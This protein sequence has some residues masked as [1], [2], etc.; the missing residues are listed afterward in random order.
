MRAVPPGQ[1]LVIDPTLE[2]GT[3]YGPDT[4]VSPLYDVAVDGL[5]NVYAAGMTYAGSTEN[6]ATTGA[7]L[8]TY[9]GNADAYL[10]KFDSSGNRLW[11]TYY[12]G[13]DLD[14]GYAV[15]ADGHH[16]VYLAGFTMS[17]D[18][19]LIATPGSLQ[20]GNGGGGNGFLAKFDGNG[21]RLWATFYGGDQQDELYSVVCDGSNNVII[22]GVATSTFNIATPG[23]FED[24]FYNPGYQYTAGLLA[25]F[26]SVGDRL[27]GTYYK[28]FTDT[29]VVADV[30][31][32]SVATDGFNLYFSAWTDGGD[33]VTTPG[34]WQPDFQGTLSNVLLAKFNDSGARQWATF[35]GGSDQ[36]NSGSVACDK[37]GNVY[38]M[39]MTT[40]DSAIASAGCFQ[41]TRAGGWDIFLAKFD[42][43]NGSRI[44]G[45]Y[46]GGPGDETISTTQIASGAAGYLYITGYTGSTTGIATAGV[47]QAV[48]GGGVNDAFLAAFDANDSEVWSTYYGGDGDDDAE[49]CAT[50]NVG[51]FGNVVKNSW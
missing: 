38:L 46:Y 32:G 17:N 24:S 9:Q 2:W 36:N 39:G 14:W 16:S 31:N 5:G 12:G 34:T 41:P 40:S 45:T 48:Y 37:I 30:Y 19:L 50:D 18:S 35:Y 44:W 20:P 22:A 27:W 7:Y 29:F 13:I 1:S 10:I 25:K 23:S 21:D 51:I 11:G 33:S 47:W 43:A 8:V 49:A 26:D 15:A 4:N 6:I 3:F 28:S 42:P